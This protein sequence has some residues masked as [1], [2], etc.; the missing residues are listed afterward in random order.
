MS[1]FDP[2][3]ANA[4]DVK[5][6][7]PNLTGNQK[8]ELEKLRQQWN[9]PHETFVL[10][11]VGS[12]GAT[13][14][15]IET[16]IMRWRKHYPTITPKQMFALVYW[17]QLT[18]NSPKFESDIALAQRSPK[19]QEQFKREWEK[20]IESAIKD[21]E[22]FAALKNVTGIDDLVWCILGLRE[23]DDQDSYGIA[24]KINAILGLRARNE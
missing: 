3:W 23:F 9:I 6:I 18:R 10:A 24:A 11:L 4:E 14:M 5:F 20:G 1:L 19:H 17:E 22:Q 8:K 16:V 13:K 2:R 21:P 7:L 15:T 12:P